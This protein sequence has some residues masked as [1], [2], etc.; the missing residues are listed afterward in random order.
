MRL[1]PA[2]PLLL[3]LG[4]AEDDDVGKGS[5]PAPVGGEDTAAPGTDADADG[6]SVEDGDC[7]DADPTVHPGATET[8]NEQDDDCDGD[9]DEGVALPWWPDADGDGHGAG[10]PTSACEAP[11]GTVGTDDDCDDTDPAI[12]PSSEEACN[13]VDDDCDGDV[14]EDVLIEVYADADGDGW[15]DAAA[16][17]WGCEGDAGTSATAGDCDDADAFVHPGIVGDA[18]DGVDADC[19]GD[20]DEDSKAGWSLLTVDTNDGAVYEI[21]PATAALTTVTT[22][23]GSARINSMDVS[24][25]GLSIVHTHN[26]DNAIRYFDPCTGSLTLIGEHGTSSLGGIAFGPGGRLFGIG[27]NDM[28]VEFDLATGRATDIGP[29]GIDIGTSGLAWDCTNQRMFGADGSGDR[30]FEVDLSTGRATNVRNTGVPFGSV[31][32]EYDR[33]SGLLYAAT[34]TAL[35]IVEPSTGAST[36]VGGLAAS[37]VD[38]LAWHPACP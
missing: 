6:H 15:G 23:T 12:S 25:N 36:Q 27:S 7:D 9:I 3:L 21:D 18:C 31:G 35:Y 13:G 22:L 1:S 28:L 11:D 17:A 26:G 10:E 8:C 34:G 20:I 29:L 4:C 38:D 32:L 24:E 37:N 16:P 30:V 2:L 5:D 19:D 33:A 14:D